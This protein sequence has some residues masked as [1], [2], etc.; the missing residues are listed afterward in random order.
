MSLSRFVFLLWSNI[1]YLQAKFDETGWICAF[2]LSDFLQLIYFLTK[3][4]LNFIAIAVKLIHQN[5]HLITKYL[6][7]VHFLISPIV[8]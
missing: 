6:R 4:L 8:L 3:M 7:V 5:D 1:F 2:F